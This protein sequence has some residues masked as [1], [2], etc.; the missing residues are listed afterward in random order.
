MTKYVRSSPITITP[1]TDETINFQCL[2]DADLI[3]NMEE[4]QKENPSDP[5]KLAKTIENAYL[6]ESGRNL[7]KKVLLN[8][9]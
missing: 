9:V 2:Y 1:K 8:I 6:T 5:E 4:H 7:A 3:V